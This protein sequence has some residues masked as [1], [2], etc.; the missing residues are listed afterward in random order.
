MS[1]VLHH[2]LGGQVSNP[3]PYGIC[4][5]TIRIVEVNS[6]GSSSRFVDLGQSLQVY[7]IWI[8]TLRYLSVQGR[9]QCYAGGAV[10]VTRLMKNSTTWI[11]DAGQKVWF[12]IGLVFAGF[13]LGEAVLFW[14]P[15]PRIHAPQGTP[16]AYWGAF[17]A[18]I[19]GIILR[20][21]KKSSSGPGAKVPQVLQTVVL[22]AGITSAV[23]G[24]PFY[25][26]A[27][28]QDVTLGHVVLV[29]VLSEAAIIIGGTSGS[30]GWL[31]AGLL[32]AVSGYFIHRIPAAQDLI[33]GFAI[34]LG[35][36]FVG[37]VRKSAV[38]S[39]GV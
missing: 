23:I 17:G 2:S 9:K 28:T 5:P 37:L 27:R 34:A 1:A 7:E 4:F 33:L 30:L 3:N 18:A 39:A 20:Y 15:D 13:Y 10:I 31:G 29:S 35:F 22:G 38:A 16:L 25:V 19:I 24:L 36:I 6:Y 12:W 11:E 14:G 21:S 32:W 26:M 8:E